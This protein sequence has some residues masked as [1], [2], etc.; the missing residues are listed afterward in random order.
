[1]AARWRATVSQSPRATGP[2]RASRGPSSATFCSAPP[3]GGGRPRTGTPMS[4]R[5]CRS[6]WPISATRWFE[7]TTPRRGRWH[8][9]RRPRR[10]NGRRASATTRCTSGSPATANHAPTSRSAA[11]ARRRA[12]RPAG[13]PPH[14]GVRRRA[15]PGRANRRR[16]ATTVVGDGSTMAATSP[17]AGIGRGEHE[18][19]RRRR[20]GVRRSSARPSRPADL[21]TGAVRRERPMQAS[22]P[23]R[24]RPMTRTPGATVMAR[25]SPRLPTSRA[26]RPARPDPGAGEDIVTGH[27]LRRQVSQRGQ[28]ERALGPPRVRDHEVGLVDRDAVDPDDVDVERP[29]APALRPHALGVG[30]QRWQTA[31]S[32][33]GGQLGLQLDDEVEEP[34]LIRATHRVGLV[35]GRHRD[36]RGSE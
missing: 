33:R 14:A 11:R 25:R 9:R 3:R 29:R 8:G 12:A 26:A 34:A 13:A 24:P 15:P 31:S 4:G 19:V 20:T 21:P 32:S 6:T 30:L 1:M 27:Q 35:D 36:D 17:I 22:R 5:R 10:T 28:H 16:W 18:Q 7:A 2:V 23:A